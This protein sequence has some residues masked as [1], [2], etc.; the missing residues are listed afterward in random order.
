MSDL[1]ARIGRRVLREDIKDYLVDAILRGEFEA[2]DRIVETRVAQHLGVSQGPVREALRDL[3][4]LGFVVSEPWK[5][6]RVREVVN[7]DLREVYPVRAVLEGLAAREAVKKA[8]PGTVEQ[9]QQLLEE[10][11]DAAGRGDSQAVTQAD[12]AFH[13]VI[14]DASGN[15]LLL[16]SWELL[17]LAT[18]TMVTVALTGRT[19]KELVERHEPVLEAIRGGDPAYAEQVMRRHIEELGEWIAEI[20]EHVTTGAT[21]GAGRDGS[22]RG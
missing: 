20:G 8:R 17:Q 11:R 1:D 2:G 18:T 19:L 3:E 12:V 15:R 5:G 6:T 22:K 16:R 13:R 10:M 21:D 4:L 14:I 9:M 7:D